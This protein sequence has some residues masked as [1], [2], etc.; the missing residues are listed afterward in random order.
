M[1]VAFLLKN[2]AVTL[3]SLN[4]KFT[5]FLTLVKSQNCSNNTVRNPL[6]LNDCLVEVV[7]IKRKIH[8]TVKQY[9]CGKSEETLPNK[10]LTAL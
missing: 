10:E 2:S 8:I 6:N 4:T 3:L 5:H 7:R 9:C 1:P